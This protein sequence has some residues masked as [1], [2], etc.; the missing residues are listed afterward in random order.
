[1]KRILV[2]FSLMVLGVQMLAMSAFGGVVS[3]EEDGSG[4]KLLREG[5]PFFV[6]GAGGGG[7]K[8]LL[9]AIGGN[10]FRTWG[11]G[12]ARAE[13]DEAQKHGLAATIG[14]WFG[15]QQHGFDYSNP[16][17]LERQKQDVLE[18]VRRLKDHPALL[19]WA[20]GNEMEIG[21]AHREAMWR[22]INDV[23][24]AVKAIDPNHPVMTVVAEIPRANVEEF[25]RFCPD[26]DILGINTYGGSGSVGERYR[27]AGGVK[28]YIVTEFGPPGQWETGKSA[29]GCP[30][31]MTS[32]EKAKWYAS[33]YRTGIEAE[34]GR[35]CLGSYAFT[36]GYKVEA[37]PTWYGLLLPD[38]TRLAATDA[39]QV[40]W[41]G[42]P[43]ANRAPEVSKIT[44]SR[45]DVREPGGTFTA[46]A[47]AS[48]PDGDPLTWTWVLVKE[49]ATYAVTGTGEPLPPGFP[50]AIVKGQGTPRVEVKLPGG[51]KFRLYAYV[52]DG[53]GSAG[54][55][56]L[57]VQGTGAEASAPRMA[58]KL[59]CVVYAD[60]EPALW[61]PS[62]Y[63]GNT[64]AIKMDLASRD[65]PRSGDTCLKVSYNAS[66]NWGG[67]LWQHP[68][69]DWGERDGGFNLEGATMLVF[70]A[71]GAEGGEKVSF[72]VGAIE[73]AKHPDTA[74]A[75]LKDIVLKP[76][77]TRYR[78]PL[79][80]RDMSRIKTGF[81][82]VVA[83]P[84]RPIA[85]Y[86]D[87]IVYT[88]D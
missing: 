23:A 65:D 12:T 8:D 4:F 78:I 41:T 30:L 69:D 18:V 17:A 84:G 26:V 40:C 56:N 24:L 66:G 46:E 52:F 63:M 10:S 88:A 49:A 33:V 68:A 32:A 58:R 19:I 59:P 53:R 25:N 82:W 76:E 37:T 51:G 28:P 7:P 85:F 75:E 47:A 39:L 2:P 45:D 79:D 44:A 57:P 11:A 74:F 31:E 42:K 72:K 80:G 77:W 22:H 60:G 27:K 55:A 54:Y 62:G 70:W 73:K 50:E 61:H 81:G 5:K 86:L 64:G 15:H 20:L 29:F 48:D 87:D 6:K 16:Q 35:L 83:N 67:V 3:L 43:P 38:N 36:W 71:R 34:R 1:M 13:L 14:F 9:A 21:N